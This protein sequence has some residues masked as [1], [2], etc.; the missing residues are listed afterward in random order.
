M[1]IRS[2]AL[3][4]VAV[5]ATSS[6]FAAASAPRAEPPPAPR[7]KQLVEELASGMREV[8][9][10]VTPEVSLPKLEITL[11]SLDLGSR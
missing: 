2:I 3:A 8:L 10:A 11:P 1:K 4:A 9:R 7:A 6:T 5:L